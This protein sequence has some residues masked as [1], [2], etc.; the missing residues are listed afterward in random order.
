MSRRRRLAQRRQCCTKNRYS[1]Y[2]AYAVAR[3]AREEREPDIEAYRCSYC[4]KWHVGHAPT[5]PL[6]KKF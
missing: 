5:P 4:K 6:R 1:K 3:K 2:T